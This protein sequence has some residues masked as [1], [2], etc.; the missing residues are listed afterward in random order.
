LRATALGILNTMNCLAGGLGIM[1]SGVLKRSYGLETVFASLT[2]TVA[3][4][5]G[6]VLIGYFLL[7]R[8]ER[9]QHSSPVDRLA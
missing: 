3:G 7:T 9:L 4:A 5:G 2:A 1:C 6:V 8:Q